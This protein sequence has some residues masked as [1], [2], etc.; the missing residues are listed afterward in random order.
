M[1]IGWIV[2]GL[3]VA[4]GLVAVF[5]F[6]LVKTV[7]DAQRSYNSDRWDRSDLLDLTTSTSAS[8]R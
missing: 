1:S 4:I 3:I 2:F 8:A 7:R 6:A 5:G